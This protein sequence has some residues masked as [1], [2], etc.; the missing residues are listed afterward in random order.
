MLYEGTKRIASGKYDKPVDI[1]SGD[2]F[3]NLAGS[4]NEMATKIDEQIKTISTMAEIDRL[5][6]S[7]FDTDYIINTLI[8]YLHNLV[9]ANHI[10]VITIEDREEGYAEINFNLDEEFNKICK[11][12]IYLDIEEIK[13]LENGKEY[14]ICNEFSSCNY[15]AKSKKMGDKYFII[16]PVFIKNKVSGVI[17]FGSKNELNLNSDKL[18]KLGELSD[19]VA[20]ALSNAEWEDKLYKQAHYDSL[21]LL[22][23]RFLFRDR[24]E[25]ALEFSI[26][27]NE[28]LAILFIDLDKFKDI[29]DSLGHVAGDEILIEV[30]ILLKENIRSYDTLARFG[31][32]EFAILLAGYNELNELITNLIRLSNRIVSRMRKPFLIKKRQLYITPSIGIAIYPRDGDNYDDLLKNADSAMYNAKR[33]GRGKYEFFERA[34]NV[35]V[36]ERLELETELRQ[37]F[38]KNQF[39]L[40]YQPKINCK[41]NRFYSAEALLRWNHPEKGQI[42]PKKFIPIAEE[43]GLI[44]PVDYWVLNTVCEQ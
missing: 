41:T 1:K 19:R 7:S 11:E 33:K 18:K 3:E 43:T 38:E 40:Y 23:N 44:I 4:F 36:N 29:N 13:E 42:Q 31:G 5:I 16:Y 35:A 30:S 8:V 37:A 15:L 20:V 27:E 32:D 12:N 10:N 34:Y 39:E 2:E 22:P 28:Y 17:I 9:D 14:L 21:T 24:V 25:R 26:R 6:L